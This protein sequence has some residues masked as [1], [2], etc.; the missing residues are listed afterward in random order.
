MKKQQQKDE[1]PEG[2]GVALKR[3]EEEERENGRHGG[4]GRRREGEQTH[5]SFP[6]MHTLYPWL[7]EYSFPTL[8]IY[9]HVG[10]CIYT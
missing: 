5:C 10:W 1:E 6:C 3:E 2:E 8:H 4:K 9:A 7:G